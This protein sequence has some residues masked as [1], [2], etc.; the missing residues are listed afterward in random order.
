LVG[1]WVGGSAA[2]VGLGRPVWHALINSKTQTVNKRAV[3]ISGSFP[4]KGTLKSSVIM[5]IKLIY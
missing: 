5:I 4:G 2:S 1:A 3:F